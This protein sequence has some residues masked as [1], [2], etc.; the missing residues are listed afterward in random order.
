M[1]IEYHPDLVVSAMPQTNE[2][3]MQLWREQC[4]RQ[5]K[6][7]MSAWL[8]YGFVRVSNRTSMDQL[9]REL[10]HCMP[11]SYAKPHYEKHHPQK[12]DLSVVQQG[13]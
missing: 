6:R 9:C 8:K 4:R 13:R 7:P 12:H 10:R 5:M 11:V 3:T 2:E 1:R